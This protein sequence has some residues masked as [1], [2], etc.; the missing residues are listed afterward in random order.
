VPAYVLGRGRP[1]RKYPPLGNRAIAGTFI[2]LP[3]DPG[4]GTDALAVAAGAPL[5]ES[6]TGTDVLSVSVAVTLPDTG[7]GSEVLQLIVALP[8]TATGTDTLTVPVKTIFLPE[9]ATGA[10]VVASVAAQVTLADTGSAGETMAAGVPIAVADTG[11]V[12]DALTVTLRIIPMADTA[13]GVDGFIAI[14]PPV[15]AVAGVIMASAN[16]GL[17]VLDSSGVQ[18]SNALVVL[19]SSGAG[20]ATLASPGLGVATV[21]T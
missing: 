7:A 6:G 16:S 3:D 4:T 5:T 9:T 15:I 18:T 20:V 8:E 11:S 2:T 19:V 1:N 14:G 17:V 21:Q 13:S 10:D 12:T